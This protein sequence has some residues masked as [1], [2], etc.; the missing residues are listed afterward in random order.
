MS[1][2]IEE[3]VERERTVK[4]AGRN[5]PTKNRIFELKNLR[6]GINSRRETTEQKWLFSLSEK[7]KHTC[8]RVRATHHV[9]SVAFQRAS[10]MV[11]NNS[12]WGCIFLKQGLMKISKIC[13]QSIGL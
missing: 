3:H 11:N 8:G 7:T 9:H 1:E 12:N 2:Q 5:T 6:I 4:E 13:G 10:R